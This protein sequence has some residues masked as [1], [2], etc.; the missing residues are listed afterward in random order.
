MI[1]AFVE[2]LIIFEVEAV[3]ENIIIT[4][5]NLSKFPKMP[6]SIKFQL[7]KKS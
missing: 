2:N 4:E 3:E 1:Y 6:I 7:N 5:K